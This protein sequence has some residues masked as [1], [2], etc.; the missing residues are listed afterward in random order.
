MVGDPSLL[1]I[2]YSVR[3]SQSVTLSSSQGLVC[4][5]LSY[6]GPSMPE[7]ILN[8]VQNDSFGSQCD[9]S[10]VFLNALRDYLI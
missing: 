1:L 8:Q 6:V 4:L 2:E 3:V 10:R 7:E 5:D 9:I